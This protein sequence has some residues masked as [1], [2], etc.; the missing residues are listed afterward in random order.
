MIFRIGPK[1]KKIK[2]AM[3]HE[4][5]IRINMRTNYDAYTKAK[6]AGV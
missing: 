2:I 4:M 5:N 1:Y 6:L 3:D